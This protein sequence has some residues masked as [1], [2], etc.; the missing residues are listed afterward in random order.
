MWIRPIDLHQASKYLLDPL[1]AP[2]P[3]QESGPG[4]HYSSTFAPSNPYASSSTSTETPQHSQDRKKDASVNVTEAGITNRNPYPSPPKSVSP[5]Q[6]R[7]KEEFASARNSMSQAST[8]I[9]TSTGGGAT[10]NGT[11]RNRKNSLPSRHPGDTSNR[12]L[13]ILRHETKVA[14]RSPHLRKKH[15]PGTDSIDT[16]DTIGA[17][18]HHE[19]P[20]DAMLLARN[21]DYKHSPVEAVRSTNEE[22]LKATP[23]EKIQDSL[24]RHIPLDGTAIVPPGERDQLG[25]GYDYEEGTDMM[26][27]NGGN[28]RRW[29]GMV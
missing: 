9:P 14:H 10:S 3:H 25:R 16:L 23:P 19:G 18:Y 20:Y 17:K 12:P 2:E 29:P 5:Q 6:S 21:T 7:F 15:F 11:G 22:A 28:Y 24:R 1:N 13:D 26:R 8:Q 27:E 4:T